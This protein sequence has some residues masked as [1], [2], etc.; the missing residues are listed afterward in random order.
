MI[1]PVREEIRYSLPE[2]SDVMLAVYDVLGRKVQVLVDGFVE[3][4]SRSVVWEAEDVAS[5]LYFVRMEVG[6]FVTVRKMALIR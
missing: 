6:D 2:A 1:W 4:G 5:G 3:A